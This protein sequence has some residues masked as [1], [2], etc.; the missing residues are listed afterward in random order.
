MAKPKI[1]ISFDFD[2]DEDLKHLLVAQSKNSD[3]PFEINDM[4]VKEA[5]SGDWKAKARTKIK[6]VDQV[7]VI[8]G[9]HTHKATG[10]EAELTM[11]QEEG[12]D[13]FL[14]HGRGDKDCYAPKS[15]NENDKI[16]EWSWKNLKL[17]IG[18]SR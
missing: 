15:A 11:A 2:H 17:L 10:V 3:S 8:C 18:G 5:M 9:E 16:Y 12:K 1:F 7:V 4:S 13:Y 14:L 6:A